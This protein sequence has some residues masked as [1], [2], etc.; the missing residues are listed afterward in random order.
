M[1]GLFFIKRQNR[2][3]FHPGGYNA[4]YKNEDKFI[5]VSS[6]LWDRISST[7]EIVDAVST[8]KIIVRFRFTAAEILGSERMSAEV[9]DQVTLYYLES[10]TLLEFVATTG[11]L[12]TVEKG[13]AAGGIDSEIMPRIVLAGYDN[14]EDS[15]IRIAALECPMPCAKNSETATL[16]CSE[17]I[18]ER[19]IRF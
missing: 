12:I 14:V 16:P 8:A 2:K 1:R 7:G 17:D 13:S 4:P 5:A 10:K 9:V 3:G 11:C 6:E 15:P 18:A 19:I